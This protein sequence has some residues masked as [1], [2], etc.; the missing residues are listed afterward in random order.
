MTLGARAAL[1]TEL[2]LTERSALL[3]LRDREGK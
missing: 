1:L 2:A 3:R